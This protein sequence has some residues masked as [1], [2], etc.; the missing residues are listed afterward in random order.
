VTGAT[1]A[2]GANGITGPTGAKGDSATDDQVLLL[3][4]DTLAISGG[5]T[6]ILADNDPINELQVLSINGDTLFISD[7]NYIILPLTNNSTNCSGFMTDHRDGQVYRVGQFGT[8]WWLLENLNIGVFRD[9]SQSQNF[10]FTFEK[11][12]PN[13]DSNLCELYGGLYRWTEIMDGSTVDGSQGICPDGWHV[14]TD[15]DWANLESYYSSNPPCSSIRYGI[16]CNYSGDELTKIGP[17]FFNGGYYYGYFQESASIFHHY[18]NRAY[19][20]TSSQNSSNI[21]QLRYFEFGNSGVGK[22][23]SLK[24]NAMFCRCVHD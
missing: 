4:N 8:A 10:N 3:L 24:E 20:W 11:Y 17:C 22:H 12:C 9:T 23:E 7:G 14:A 2:A 6:V 5:N 16:E 13:N 21:S 15:Q 19:F 1:G 18:G